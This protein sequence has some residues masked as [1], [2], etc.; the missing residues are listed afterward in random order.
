MF[1]SFLLLRPRISLLQSS[2]LFFHACLLFIPSIFFFFFLGTVS[3]V[4][5]SSGLKR[6]KLT[7]D[8]VWCVVFLFSFVLSSVCLCYYRSGF[9]VF[10]TS[11][12]HDFIVFSPVF[13]FVFL[14]ALAVYFSTLC[15]FFFFVSSLICLFR[16]IWK[17]KCWRVWFLLLKNWFVISEKIFLGF[18]RCL[19]SLSFAAFF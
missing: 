11:L 17:N 13:I 12:L 9:C 14:S 2:I 7:T 1:A 3:S 5:S 19:C 8:F 4:S 16:E 6:S 10:S 15:I 18:F